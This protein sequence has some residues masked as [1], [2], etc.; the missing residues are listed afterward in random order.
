VKQTAVIR[1]PLVNNPITGKLE[2]NKNIT[3]SPVE[4]TAVPNSIKIAANA[5]AVLNIVAKLKNSYQ[6]A[7]ISKDDSD[8]ASSSPVEKYTHLLIARVKD[9]QLMFSFI[10]EASVLESSG[11]DGAMQ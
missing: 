7:N 10:I 5:S 11:K 4:F 6:L 2:E 8:S 3:Q 9:T 1:G